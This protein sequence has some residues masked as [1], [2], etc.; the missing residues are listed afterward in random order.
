MTGGD[1]VCVGAVNIRA[2]RAIPC[3]SVGGRGDTEVMR[4][5]YDAEFL[6][7]TADAPTPRQ[8]TTRLDY[9]HFSVMLDTDRRLA[10]LTAVNIH[11]ALLVDVE[12][13]RDRWVF[14]E[15]VRVEEQVGDE[16][17][18]DNPFDRGHL[19]R[20]RDP[21]WGDDARAANTDTFHYTNAA[22]QVDLFNQ[23]PEL[24]LGLEDHL[25][26]HAATYERRLSVFTGPVL[27]GDD[28]LYRGVPI[29]RRFFKIVAWLQ[30]TSLATTAYLLDQSDLVDQ[31]I[32]RESRGAQADAPPLGAYRTFQSSVAEICRLA[33]LDAP[34]LIA[35][36]VRPAATEELRSFEQV[37]QVIRRA[38]AR[39][40]R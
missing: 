37:E 7:L 4:N 38:R 16:L 22:P 24:W 31:V 9:T 33:G 1:D 20:R 40:R 2:A 26:D 17:Y 35:A 13:G 30:E 25:L 28:P 12:R 27:D 3:V 19:V 6:G 29:P 14:D 10:A 23:S 39:L 32:A 36:D 21:V 15:R 18:R 11:G 8:A 34:A 5:G